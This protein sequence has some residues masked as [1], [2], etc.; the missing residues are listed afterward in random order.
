VNSLQWIYCTTARAVWY[1]CLEPSSRCS[2]KYT[3]PGDH[4]VN[5]LFNSICNN[6]RL[7]DSPSACKNRFFNFTWNN[8]DLIDSFS[9]CNNWVDQFDIVGLPHLAQYAQSMITRLQEIMYLILFLSYLLKEYQILYLVFVT[10]DSPQRT[11]SCTCRW[12]PNSVTMTPTKPRRRLFA[13][14]LK[15]RK[16]RVK[17]VTLKLWSIRKLIKLKHE[18][19]IMCRLG[20]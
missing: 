16:P 11:Y 14:V 3:H 19:L 15:R 10:F 9:I 20:K 5:R 4:V 13:T 12:Y 17:N 2:W 18:T 8:I 1:P 7:I 6:L